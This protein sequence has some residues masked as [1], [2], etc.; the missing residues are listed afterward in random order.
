MRSWAYSLLRIQVFE[1]TTYQK[2]RAKKQY[3]SLRPV[4]SSISVTSALVV[5]HRELAQYNFTDFSPFKFSLGDHFIFRV[6]PRGW[7]HSSFTFRTSWWWSSLPWARTIHSRWLKSICLRVYFCFAN[8]TCY[9]A[10]GWEAFPTKQSP[11]TS[12]IFCIYLAISGFFRY[13]YSEK[14]V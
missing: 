10:V 2:L 4:L 5:L 9:L 7:A 6:K 8:W 3:S 13:S 14:L 11:L 1:S 12:F